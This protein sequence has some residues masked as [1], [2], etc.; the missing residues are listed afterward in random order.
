M[1]IKL[2][3]LTPLLALG[4]PRWRSAQHRS[5][6]PHPL[7]SKSCNESVQEVCASPPAT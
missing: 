4:L 1:K 2:T 7:R 5:L 3:Y 6:Q